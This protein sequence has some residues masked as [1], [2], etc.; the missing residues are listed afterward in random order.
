MRIANSLPVL[1]QKLSE[2]TMAPRLPV[3]NIDKISTYMTSGTDEGEG[4]KTGS[5]ID[6]NQ[7]RKKTQ[8]HINSLVKQ[9]WHPKE[10]VRGIIYNQR[11][12]KK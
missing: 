1:N 3:L 5:K 12:R 4:D 8:S 2:A 7:N 11:E 6:K 9:Q 10:Q